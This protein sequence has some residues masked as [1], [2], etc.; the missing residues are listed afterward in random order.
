M[1]RGIILKDGTSLW[2][3]HPAIMRAIWAARTALHE[4]GARCVVTSLFDGTHS[5]NSFHHYGMAVDIRSKE[6][7]SPSIKRAV[8]DRISE[9]LGPEYDVI[10]EAHNTPNEHYHIEWEGGREIREEW[11]AHIFAGQPAP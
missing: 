5:E 7:S 11:L 8:R 1:D 6:L 10:L 9:L 4:R 2:G 3:A